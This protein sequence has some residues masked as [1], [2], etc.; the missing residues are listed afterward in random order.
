MICYEADYELEDDMVKISFTSYLCVLL[1]G[2]AMI[3]GCD[4]NQ[5]HRD[6]GLPLYPT[7]S[8]DGKLLVVLDRVGKEIPRLRIK[9]LDRNDNWLEVPAPKYTSSIRFGLTDYK[10]LLT[11][12]RQG[13]GGASQLSL[14]DVSQPS[15]P[16]EVLYE[17]TRVA[18][19]VETSPGQILVRICPQPPGESACVG[20]HGL[21][22]A[23]IKNGQATLISETLGMI[24][25]GTPNVVGENGF[26][27][28][29]EDERWRG[30]SGPGI[31]PGSTKIFSYGL[32]GKSAPL[33]DT[34]FLDARSGRM[35]CDR[36]GDRCLLNYLTDE[37]L[38][39]YFVWGFKVIH[40]GTICNLSGLKGYVENFSLTPDGNTAV[41]S[42]S[43]VPEEPRRVV[44]LRFDPGQ[45]ESISTHQIGFGDSA[46]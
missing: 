41:M 38:N 7:I 31:P 39:S 12:A 4:P 14:W 22:W 45:C 5:A 19:P 6:A 35:E 17:G 32:P 8:G 15:K 1:L 33:I 42:I 40:K 2:L 30:V 46:L 34:T 18:F 44:V 10:L 36:N 24:P 13:P 11:H 25:L 20:G 37:R 27:W 23:L 21:V 9:W 29:Y 16:S 28:N 26:F 43:R 3:G